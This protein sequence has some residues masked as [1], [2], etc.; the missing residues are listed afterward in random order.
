ME[1]E[2]VLGLDG[3]V[4][5]SV[6]PQRVAATAERAASPEEAGAMAD[7]FRLLADPTRMRILSALAEAGE[8]CVCDV[9]ATVDV[10]ESAVSHALRLLRTSGVVR[11]RRDG[12]LMYYRLDDAHVRLLLDV[13]R[14]HLD[15]DR[16]ERP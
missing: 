6:D 13:T 16:E 8:L 10:A 1:N 12:R 14:A 5:R 11:N 15:H 2:A 4:T 9:A 7:L 3:C